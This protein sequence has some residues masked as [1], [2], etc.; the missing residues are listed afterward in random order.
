MIQVGSWLVQGTANL[1]PNGPGQDPEQPAILRDGCE[2]NVTITEDM[3]V[4]IVKHMMDKS[5]AIRLAAEVLKG[6]LKD[7]NPGYRLKWTE[8][9]R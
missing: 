4:E 3:A 9:V 2:F 6:E 7:E 1:V 8:T 5:L